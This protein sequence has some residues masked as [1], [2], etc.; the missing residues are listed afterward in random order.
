MRK[1]EVKSGGIKIGNESASW[2]LL[3]D[4]PFIEMTISVSE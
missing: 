4:S 3:L 2:N 1:G